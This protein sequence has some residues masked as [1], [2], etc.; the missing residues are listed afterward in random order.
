VVD[1]SLEHRF[2]APPAAVLTAM[3]DGDFYRTLALPDLSLP[4][5]AACEDDGDAGSLTLRYTFTGHLDPFA[6]G[7]LGGGALVWTQ[8]VRV[9]RSSSTATL[10]FA[11]DLAPDRLHG[12][13][14]FRLRA[15][16]MG[17]VRDL[18]GE[19]VV[20]VP[21]VGKR[22]ER[23]IVGGLRTRLDLEA[24]ALETRLTQPR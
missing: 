11:A 4:E 8:T 21:L 19:L 5:V 22:A 15:A 16:E 10:L 1:F 23:T 24:Q 7:L 2:G 18:S 9:V 20:G 17:C 6:R 12:G 3:I 13:G 14:Q